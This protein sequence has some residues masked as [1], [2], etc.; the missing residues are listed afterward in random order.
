M[1]IL[2]RMKRNNHANTGLQIGVSICLFGYIGYY[3]D[4]KNG[5]EPL[6]L[7]IGIFIAFGYMVYELWKLTQSK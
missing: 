6:G 2:G 3:L 4:E 5:T 7:L 1:I